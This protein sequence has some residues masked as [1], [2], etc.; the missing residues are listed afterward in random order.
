M[1]PRKVIVQVVDQHQEKDEDTFWATVERLEKAG[2]RKSITS[3]GK[4]KD[5]GYPDLYVVLIKEEWT[6]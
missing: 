6:E 2:Y 3:W 5:K 4:Y 1:M